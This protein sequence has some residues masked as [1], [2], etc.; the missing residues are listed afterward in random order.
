MYKTVLLLL[1]LVST[2]AVSQTN[3]HR[4][5]TRGYVVLQSGRSPHAIRNVQSL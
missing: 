1:V 3:V 5:F 2:V 4:N